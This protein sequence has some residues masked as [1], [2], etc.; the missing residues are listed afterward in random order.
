MKNKIIL[1][2]I[3][4]LSSIAVK[5]QMATFFDPAVAYSR[6]LLEKGGK[7][8]Y[9]RVGNF[10]VTGS[11]YIYSETLK[12]D[13]YH[14]GK[15][16]KDVVYKINNYAKELQIAT[17]VPGQVFLVSIDDL[18]SLLLPAA[19]N[20]FL[21]ADLKFVSSKT[22]DKSKKLFLQELQKGARF[23]LYKSYNTEINIPSDNYAQTD[24]REFNLVVEYYY[25]DVQDPGVLKSVKPNK[26]WLAKSFKDN[27]AVEI[28]ENVSLTG[29]MDLALGKFF[30]FLK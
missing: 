12:G 11:P 18:D 29:N 10:K 30:N 15:I 16:A 17:D 13:V 28:L 25:T 1:M 4:F 22:I 2:A 23:T 14:S 7:G 20:E 9:I 27:N 3:V 6:V 19:K 24:L 8:T 26:K 21:T 5:A